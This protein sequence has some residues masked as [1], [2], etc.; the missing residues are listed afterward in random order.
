MAG[1]HRGRN[2]VSRT[3]ATMSL[4]KVMRLFMP[5]EQLT[6]PE[7]DWDAETA[8]LYTHQPR[9]MSRLTESIDKW[10]ITVP[11]RLCYGPDGGCCGLL[12]TVDGCHRI[13]I[14]RTLGIGR[15]PVADAWDEDTS[16]RYYMDD[17]FADDPAQTPKE[18]I[19]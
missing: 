5:A 16:W 12:H 17:S 14:A 1:S 9:R 8:W 15:I 3:Q 18:G 10:G 4:T 11:V 19:F 6:V 7:H 13:V 2:T